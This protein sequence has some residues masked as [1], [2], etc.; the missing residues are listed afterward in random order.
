[1]HVSVYVSDKS[2]GVA[3]VHIWIPDTGLSVTYEYT[4][5]EEGRNVHYVHFI[6]ETPTI[7]GVLARLP[8]F[9]VVEIRNPYVT[10]SSGSG[11]YAIKGSELYNAGYY[12]EYIL[13]KSSNV[14]RNAYPQ[15]DTTNNNILIYYVTSRR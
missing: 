13:K 10:L 4:M 14:E 11:V 5:S 12:I 15:F 6:F 3:K 9:D 1:V 7:N 2:T 8:R